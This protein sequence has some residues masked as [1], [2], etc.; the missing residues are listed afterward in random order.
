MIE[1]TVEWIGII[2]L[3]G[4]MSDEASSSCET[5]IVQMFSLVPLECCTTRRLTVEPLAGMR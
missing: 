5:W 4:L 2:V 1:S 3:L